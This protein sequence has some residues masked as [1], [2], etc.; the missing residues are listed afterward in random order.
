VNFAIFFARASF[1]RASNYILLP[2]PFEPHLLEMTITADLFQAYLK[3]P[4]KCWLRAKRKCEAA[5]GNAYSEWVE[6]QVAAHRSK[7]IERLFATVSETE[8]AISLQN[9]A[10]ITAKCRLTANVS[11]NA[12]CLSPRISN[13][14]K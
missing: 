7:G 12:F 2:L 8:C 13:P 1:F 4:M 9:E 14:I 5:A 10:L 6:R 11:V 3:C